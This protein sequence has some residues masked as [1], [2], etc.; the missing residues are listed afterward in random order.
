LLA[1]HCLER[2]S[3]GLAAPPGWWLLQ[4]RRSPDGKVCARAHAC[5][6]ERVRACALSMQLCQQS[7]CGATHPS[8]C[9]SFALIVV[10]SGLPARRN[11]I[12]GRLAPIH[13]PFPCS[14]PM[15]SPHRPAPPP[16]P[17]PHIRSCTAPSWTARPKCAA[18]TRRAPSRCQTA[19]PPAPRSCSAA[20]E[21]H[22]CTRNAAWQAF[23]TA[24][25]LT[26][27][28]PAAFLHPL[29]A[30][31]QHVPLVARPPGAAR[32]LGLGET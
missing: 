24:P 7:P 3:D 31:V 11:S 32:R 13:S 21:A 30:A 25:P 8:M 12:L 15:H 2:D 10:H 19:V 4:S 5:T 9:A 14:L 6:C 29:A 20:A 17:G 27:A 23:E 16:P 28:A 22:A 26:S 18:S 1:E